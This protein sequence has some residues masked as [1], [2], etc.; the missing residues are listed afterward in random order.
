VFLVFSKVLLTLTS[1]EATVPIKLKPHLMKN[2]FYMLL[3]LLF[4]L[5]VKAQST[6]HTLEHNGLTRSY[7]L[8]VPATY[9]GNAAVPLVFNLHGYTSNAMQQELYGDF[10]NIADT[11]NFILVH[12]DGTL[13]VGGNRF[14]NAFGATGGV[15]DVGFIS[16]IID[17]IDEDYNIDLARV[18]SCGMSNGGFMSYRLACELGN[19][20]TAVASVTG[21]MA[22][23]APALC[24]PVKPTPIMQIHGTAD[25]T[26]PYN[27][28]TTM[29]AIET[30]VDFWVEKNNCNTT[31]VITDVPDI[32]TTDM[33]TA[34]HFLYTDG[35]NGSTVEFFKVIGGAHTWP[36]APITIG[37]TN[38]DFDAS[39]EIWRFFSQFSSVELVSVAA[40][41][42]PQTV[43]CFPVPVRE[44]LHIQSDNP[45]NQV[46]IHDVTGK[47][48]FAYRGDLQTINTSSWQPGIY[49]I[50]FVMDDV[51]ETQRL[52]VE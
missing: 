18:Y 36:N 29:T 33:C 6:V 41:L 7:R 37:V 19:R 14:W 52:L 51:T 16:A 5:Q 10:R 39:V 50:S 9:T 8:Y 12:P 38:R 32:N 46:L 1:F 23:N 47:E 34:Q 26:V 40:H 31:P 3:V 27:G 2:T 22:I 44:M 13:D 28:N 43:T 25:P 4:A 48:I 42:N 11:A 15:D 21:T 49:F 45:I 17:K 30:L 20:I 35:T 24:N